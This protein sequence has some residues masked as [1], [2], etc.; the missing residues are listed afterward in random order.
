MAPKGSLIEQGNATATAQIPTSGINRRLLLDC[1]RIKGFMSEYICG[2]IR[3]YNLSGVK[4]ER[5]GNLFYD[6]IFLDPVTTHHV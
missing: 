2:L 6:T 5:A 4:D 3:M 1:D